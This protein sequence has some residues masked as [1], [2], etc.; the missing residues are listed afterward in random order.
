VSMGRRGRSGECGGRGICEH[1]RQKSTY[2]ESGG[3]ENYVSIANRRV[4]LRS[5]EQQSYDI[6]K[7]SDAVKGLRWHM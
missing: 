5:L 2:K 1:G 6:A 4:C 3:S 7:R